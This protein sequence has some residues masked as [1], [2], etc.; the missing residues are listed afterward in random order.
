MNEY[1]TF[2]MVLPKMT[3][4]KT[5]F[6]EKADGLCV[7]T[8]DHPAQANALSAQTVEEL[9]A[10]I[11]RVYQAD[12]TRQ[13]S[14]DGPTILLIQAAGKHFCGGF[15]F[16]DYQDQ[17]QAELLERF[18]RI[19]QLLQRIRY[20]PFTTI[21]CAQGAAFGAGADLVAACRCRI[22]FPE[23]RLRFPGSRFGV[24]LGQS[25]LAY[26]VGPAMA[27][28]LADEN[29]LLDAPSALA[30]GLLTHLLDA[31][32]DVE[33]TLQGV[34]QEWRAATQWSPPNTRDQDMAALVASLTPEGLHGRIAAY[35]SAG[36]TARP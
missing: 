34:R 22:G 15:D 14:G 21:A 20:A 27:R 16:T 23:T 26:L 32:G 1:R 4:V 2:E 30:C 33:S 12:Q 11:D 29:L 19:E 31:P 9:H 3:P 13:S 24:V 10:W 5:R 25:H 35:L 8:L 18:V 28:K 17:S 7:I 36:K 6:D